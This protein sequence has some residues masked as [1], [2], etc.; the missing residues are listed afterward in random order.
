M[1]RASVTPAL[2]D[3]SVDVLFS[4]VL[5]P[6]MS[7]SRIEQDIYFVWPGAI[8][9]D[10]THGAADPALAREVTQAGFTVIDEGRVGLTARNL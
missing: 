10:P 5:P 1:L 7:A 9:H 2:G 8:V 6:T 3:T 4:L